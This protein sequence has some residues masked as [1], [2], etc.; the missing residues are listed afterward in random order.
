LLNPKSLKVKKTYIDTWIYFYLISNTRKIA[1]H[2]HVDNLIGWFK[3]GNWWSKRSGGWFEE[4]DSGNF[5]V[6]IRLHFFAD[7]TPRTSWK[8]SCCS[9][10]CCNCRFPVINSLIFKKNSLTF[11][12]FVWRWEFKKILFSLKI[13]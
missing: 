4:P 10:V 11:N 12:R 8:D 13:D 9:R 1:I 7:P 5:R 2:T 3:R 6:R